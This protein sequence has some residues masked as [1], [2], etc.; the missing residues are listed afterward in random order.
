[1]RAIIQDTPRTVLAAIILL[2]VV[3]FTQQPAAA[4]GQTLVRLS[5]REPQVGEDS[6]ASLEVQLENVENLYGFDIR[7]SFDPNVVEVVDADPDVDVIQVQHGNLLNLDF[8]V[9]NGADNAEGTVWYAITQMNPSEPVSGSG[10]AFTVTFRGKEAGAT[11]PLRITHGQLV[12]RSGEEIPTTTEDGEIVVVGPEE[13]PPEPTE[14]PTRQPSFLTPTPGPATAGDTTEESGSTEVEPT[15]NP[16]ETPAPTDRPPSEPSP[17]PSSASSGD[18][19]VSAGEAALNTTVPAATEDESGTSVA[20]SDG[21]EL[22]DTRSTDEAE[23]GNDPPAAPSQGISPS[24]EVSAEASAAEPSPT[25]TDTA[26]G[27]GSGSSMDGFPL[28]H[29]TIALAAIGSLLLLIGLIGLQ[30]FSAA[31]RNGATETSGG[32]R[33]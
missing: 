26:A 30:M 3:T 9:R 19:D 14:A 18:E 22:T 23:A 5:P 33:P 2:S 20:S 4:R 32:E 1:M 13:A 24:P 28:L 17:T 6:T 7:L 16:T 8:V 27:S 15:S 10:V 11:S 21:I 31:S 25:P 29:S 12:T